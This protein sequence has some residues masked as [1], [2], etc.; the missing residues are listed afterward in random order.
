MSN[1]V[2]AEKQFA[3]VPVGMHQAVCAYVNDIGTRVGQYEGRPTSAKKIIVSWELKET[4]PDGDYMGQP[5]MMSKYYTKS[6][7]ES[8]N[9]RKD[10][11]SWRGRPF[12]ETELEGFD[13]DNLVGENCYLN[14]T[15]NKKGKSIISTVNPL[16]KEL[17]KI[18]IVNAVMSDKFRAWIDAERA[19][20]VEASGIPQSGHEIN[21]DVP[22]PTDDRDELPF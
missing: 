1:I 5:F 7:V 3:Q 17:K 9:L 16:P 10:L 11:E 18:N 6:L 19:R 2:K 12:T 13:L 22:A 20:S 15:P 4:I 21:Q 14:V 8:A